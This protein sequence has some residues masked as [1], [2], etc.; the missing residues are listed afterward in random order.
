MAELGLYPA[1]D[2]LVGGDILAEPDG[3][4]QVD[5]LERAARNGL[6]DDLVLLGDD[7]LTGDDRVNRCPG[8]R[9]NVDSVV[10][11]VGAV[12]PRPRPAEWLSS[13]ERPRVAESPP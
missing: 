13:V 10:E 4:G 5:V 3:A 8:G 1:E 2:R 7:H 12:L 6:D 11:R 9:D